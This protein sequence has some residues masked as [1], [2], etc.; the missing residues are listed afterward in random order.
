MMA[1]ACGSSY[2]GAQVG[3]SQSDIGLGNNVKTLSENELERKEKKRE[4]WKHGSSGR[5]PA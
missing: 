3:G 4:S 1:C 5:V 2:W